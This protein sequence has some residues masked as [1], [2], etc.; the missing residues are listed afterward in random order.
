MRGGNFATPA[1]LMEIFRRVYVNTYVSPN[2]VGFRC[3]YPV[4]AEAAA[5]AAE[6]P[7][8]VAAP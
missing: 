3:V 6:T 2:Y 7:V 1:A 8:P 5:E 4:T